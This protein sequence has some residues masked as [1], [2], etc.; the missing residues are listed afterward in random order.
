VDTFISK[1]LPQIFAS[2]R[3]Q[4]EAEKDA[5]GDELVGVVV[6]EFEP[7]FN[8][9]QGT[10]PYFGGSERLTLAEVSHLCFFLRRSAE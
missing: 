1:V 9:S 7:L 3:A 2:Q 5:A 6:K 8:W 4:S 10:G